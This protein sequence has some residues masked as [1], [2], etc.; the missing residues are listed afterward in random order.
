MLQ[1]AELNYTPVRLS[2]TWVGVGQIPKCFSSMWA[3]SIEIW[4]IYSWNWTN[5]IKFDISK[6]EY[7]QIISKFRPFTV[8]FRPLKSILE[9]FNGEFE[10]LIPRFRLL[11]GEFEQ[12]IS[13]L[14]F[15]LTLY[16]ILTFNSP[17]FDITCSSSSL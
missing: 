9:L 5:I 17:N 11:R 15:F 10:H 1:M 12:M 14:E 16:P 4:A 13:K 2:C 8:G 7:E 6:G 3:N